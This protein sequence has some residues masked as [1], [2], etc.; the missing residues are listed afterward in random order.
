MADGQG[1]YRDSLLDHARH[2]R[3][4]G[5]LERP[6]LT[7]SA[8][9]PLCGDQ[10]EVTLALTEGSIQDIRGTV[11]G[12]VIAQASC[13]MMAE[14]IAGKPLAEALALGEALRAA[15]EDS[16]AALPE[17]LAAL[18]PLV[19]VRRHRSRIGCALLPWQALAGA[20]TP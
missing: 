18:A 19:E 15:L 9:N 4:A 5:R 10:L 16:A 2:P 14:L 12:C 6:D 20:R 13:S 3:R 11:R 7:G 1:L 8:H 17:S